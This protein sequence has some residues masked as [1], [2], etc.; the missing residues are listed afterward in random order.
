VLCAWTCELCPSR[1]RVRA[2]VRARAYRS[3]LA[4][5]C[6]VDDA[7]AP[8]RVDRAGTARGRHEAAA[9][10]LHPPCPHFAHR[11]QL[12]ASCAAFAA[13][14]GPR[15]EIFPARAEKPDSARRKRPAGRAALVR[16]TAEQASGLGN[17]HAGGPA[18]S[19][20][21]TAGHPPARGS[22]P[23][24]RVGA[25]GRAH[26]STKSQS[27]GGRYHRKGRLKHPLK[28][29]SYKFRPITSCDGSP[30]HQL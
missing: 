29:I 30:H 26:S 22:L 5:L 19:I 11:S 4:P 15:S 12:P 16:W 2:R 8:H 10:P 17:S 6:S 24:Q 14:Y 23:A 7:A 28:S 9:H 27:N 13:R 25:G 20:G 21:R 18:G 3:D 1:A